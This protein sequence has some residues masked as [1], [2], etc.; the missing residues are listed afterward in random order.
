MIKP[1]KLYK[2]D[3]VAVVSPSWGGPSVFPHVYE[4]GIR[5]LECLGLKIKE[6]PSARMA[7][8]YLDRNPEFRAKDINDAFADKAVKAIFTSIGGDDSIRILSYLDLDIIRQNPK[9]FTG[10]SDAT[11]LTTFLNQNGLVTLNG[12]S[13]M[14]GYSQWNELGNQFQEHIRTF[15]FDNPESYEYKPYDFFTQGYLDWSKKENVGK[16]LPLAKNTGWT[17]LQGSSKVQG[18][19]FGGCIEVFEFLKGTKFWPS[20]DFWNGKILFFETSEDKPSPNQVKYML[21]N[22]GVQG[23]YDK[24]SALLIGRPRDYSPEE[25]KELDDYLLKIVRDEFHSDIPIVSNMDFSHTDPQWIM[26]LGIKAELD[27]DKKSFRLLEKVFLD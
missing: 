26:P 5:T 16:I 7:A 18:E 23:I 8:D 9:I 15:L 10:Y 1:K 17:W 2:G 13:I 11:T 6:F 22:Y 3:V 21:R 14:A 24:I 4:S 19:L 27:C 20:A 25:K 12:P